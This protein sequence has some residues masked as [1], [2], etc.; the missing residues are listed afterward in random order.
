LKVIAKQFTEQFET[1]IP[2]SY[3]K[4]AK[5]HQ[6]YLNARYD[7]LIPDYLARFP[8]LFSLLLDSFAISSHS[9]SFVRCGAEQARKNVNAIKEAIGTLNSYAL[10][11]VIFCLFVCLF[12]CFFFFCFVFNFLFIHHA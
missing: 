11:D 7:P 9:R 5:R 8:T 4:S 12:V 1:P 2:L 6:R 10:F 3:N